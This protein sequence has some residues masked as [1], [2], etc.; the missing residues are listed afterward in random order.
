MLTMPREA[1]VDALVADIPPPP[2]GMADMVAANL[3]GVALLPA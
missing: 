2:S 1:F 3:R